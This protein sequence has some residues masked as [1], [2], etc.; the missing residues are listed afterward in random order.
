[1]FIP[2]SDFAGPVDASN[3]DAVQLF[4]DTGND[5]VDGQI[6]TIGVLGPKVADFENEVVVDLELVKSVDASMVNNGDVVTWTLS[7]TNNETNATSPASGVVVSDVLPSGVTFVNANTANG[8]FAGNQWTLAD[9]LAPGDTATLTVMTTIDA[10]VTGGTVL[11][12]VAEVT[13]QNETDFDSVPDN[14]DGDQSEDD[15]DNASVT[16]GEFID[17]EVTKTSNVMMVNNNDQVTF[18]VTV[19]NNDEN[20]NA[21]ATGVVVSDPLP[22]G[23]TLVS[24]TPSAGTFVAGDW[25]LGSPLAPGASET[26]MIVASVDP[27]VPGDTKITNVAQVTA[28]NET[29]DDSVVDNDDGDQSE[30]D[31]SGVMLMVGQIIDLE[32]TKTVDQ[33]VVEP[34]D[35][36]NWTIE[37]TN[38]PAT[39]NSD[40]TNVEVTDVLP[41]GV[42]FVSATP[43]GSGTF[44]GGVWSLV[45]PLAPG[46]TATL[47]LTSTV[48]AGIGGSDLINA[49][50]VTAADQS[51]FDST[52]NNDD[53]DRSEDEEDEA[54]IQ[55]ARIIDLEIE[56]AA[57]S[58]MVLAGTP[59]TFT[60]TLTNNATNA[61]ADATGV[62][63]TDVL[64]TGLSLVNSSTSNGSFAGTT[65]TLAN[66]LAPGASATLTLVADVSESAPDSIENVVQVASANEIDFDSME[67]N[68]DGDQS[69][70]DE[71]NV[72]LAVTPLA[73][74]LELTKDV[75]S[76]T[77]LQ[78][79][80]VTFTISLTNNPA[81]AN[82][83]ATG[84]T[85]TDLLPTGLSLVTSSA[86]NGS[87]NGG[88]WTLANPLAPGATA[89]LT[90]VAEVSNT[91]PT[92]LENV[93]QVASA[94][95]M[96]IDSVVSND[97]GDQSEDDEDN[98]VL[99]VTPLVIDLEL[100]KTANGS[101]FDV[102][103]QVTFTISL[104]N[105]PANANT[106]ATGV[107][108]TDTL[109]AGLSFV[110]ANP[111]NGTF[112]GSVWTLGSPLAPGAT[113]TLNLVATVESTAGLSAENVAQVSAAN[114]NDIDSVVDNDNGDQSEDDEDNVV[115]SVNPQVIDLELTKSVSASEVSN[116]EQVTWT[117]SLTNN[118]AVANSA[119]TGVR[120]TDTLPA[121]LT[122]QSSSPSSGTFSGGVW[123]LGGPIAPGQTETLNLVTVVDDSVAGGEVL[124]NVAQVSAAN[125]N[126]IDSTPNNDNGDQSED[127]EDNARIT[128]PAVVDLDI[129][130]SVDQNVVNVGDTLTWTVTVRNDPLTGNTAATGV[131]VDE[132]L[133]AGVTFVSSNATNGS[134][135]SGSGIWTLA[136]PLAP[137]QSATL[138][139][140]TT[141]DEGASGSNLENVAQ[142]LAAD[143]T[144]V[145]SIPANDDGDQ[146]ED[147]EDPEEVR[148]AARRPLS[149]RDLLA[150]AG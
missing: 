25:T 145:D 5:S 4:I 118:A 150:S 92:T 39:A 56:K 108:V 148:V 42:T 104:T 113:E 95:E 61:N 90:L 16:L 45:D 77:V 74:D 68:D 28:A 11:T 3:V 82:T 26:L 147:D 100:T 31:E 143:Q 51:D 123:T 137:G 24:A 135:N 70:D 10:G 72:V 146:S 119:A 32:L 46:A 128:V 63:V 71:D 50:Q 62:T 8:S 14:D 15:E 44:A 109:P 117:I 20:A 83:D 35:T 33:S 49:A 23:L 120:V 140:V 114:E 65:W 2:F 27:D 57:N 136:A 133:P 126:D 101:N 40:A 129:D 97:D 7:I 64:P 1:M 91:A 107:T 127:E 121:G 54:Q 58:T 112:A 29:D 89:N 48:N 60:I 79:D 22:S 37:V 116:G 52:P 125:E 17:L 34:G 130:K 80:Q 88:T 55:L 43:S 81:N 110:S 132:V 96:D 47:I 21:D 106:A 102:G 66:P 124:V 73:I 142:V 53:G 38:N 87:F 131:V 19:S 67:G 105:N 13:A 111:S 78:G 122:L 98:V 115:L 103:D 75:D 18:T 99:T 149:K 30:D 69:E 134:Y 138:T 12:N 6:D 144:D 84:V 93:A 59:V 76:S 85:V 141:V 139:V 94:N 41:A 86:D 9:P 36:V